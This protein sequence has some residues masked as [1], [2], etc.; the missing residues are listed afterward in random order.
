MLA[1]MKTTKLIPAA[2]AALALGG[3]ATATA[4]AAGAQSAAAR[5]FEGRIVSVDRA[6]RTF[7]LRDSERGTMRI[8]VTS[9]TSFERIAGFAGLH[10]GM[11]RVE[12]TVRRSNGRWVAT[13]VERSGG[14]GEHGGGGR[15]RD[16]PEDD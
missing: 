1:P 3:T 12:G 7:R 5:H 2:L 13:R 6:A 10:A 9:S 16:H 14:G 11:G 15:G 8:R 4:T